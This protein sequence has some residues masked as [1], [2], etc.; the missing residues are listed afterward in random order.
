MEYD[1]FKPVRAGNTITALSK[2]KDIT[3]REGKSGKM[4]FFTIETAFTNQNDDLVCKSRSIT[5]N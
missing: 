4:A 3:V 1:F 5:I 2:I